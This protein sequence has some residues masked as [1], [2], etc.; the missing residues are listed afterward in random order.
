[1]AEAGIA[2]NFPADTFALATKHFA[3]AL[4]F[5]NHAIDFVY[6]RTGNAPDQ[7]VETVVNRLRCRLL[8]LVPLTAQVGDVTPHEFIAGIITER[9]IFRAPY[10]ESLK[11]AFE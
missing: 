1:V 9:G 8:H 11:R 7:R 10:V 4:Q 3:H 5:K 2:G 6:R